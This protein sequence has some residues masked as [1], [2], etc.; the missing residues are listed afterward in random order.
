MSNFRQ[1]FVT[2]AMR[3]QALRFGEF[4]TK[5]GRK[6]P[7]FFNSGLFNDGAAMSALASFYAQ[8]ALASGVPFDMIFGPAYKG[9]TLAAGMAMKLADMGHNMPFAFNRKE[10]KDH[11]EG[12]TIVGAP[13][14]GRVMI[15]D[16]VISAGTS[17]RESI[18]LIRAAGATPA[19]VVISLDRQERGLGILSA[20]QEVSQQHGIPVIAVATLDDIVATLSTSPAEAAKI[21]E[22]TAYRQQYGAQSPQ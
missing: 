22:I 16:D 2:F 6:S 18:A 5:A 13:L 20:A 19:G 17:V 14:S 4:Q 21:A 12:G 10:A 11:G 15:V 7:Y 1:E 8:A 3:Q 9:I